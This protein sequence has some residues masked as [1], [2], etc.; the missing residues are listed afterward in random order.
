M[1]VYGSLI[2]DA[3]GRFIVSLL[4]QWSGRPARELLEPVVVSQPVTPE[5]PR[6]YV[7]EFTLDPIIASRHGIEVTHPVVTSSGASHVSSGPLEL[8][9]NG[10]PF[11]ALGAGPDRAQRIASR[12]HRRIAAAGHEQLAQSDSGP[13]ER[14]PRLASSIVR[15]PSSAC[16]PPTD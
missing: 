6:T 3:L 11:L 8:S 9:V 5:Q 2:G 10:K 13:P 4:E 14:S 7:R 15:S 1:N 16:L 12:Y